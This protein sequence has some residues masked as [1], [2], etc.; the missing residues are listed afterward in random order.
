MV[1]ADIYPPRAGSG[2]KIW[3]RDAVLQGY[4]L[5]DPRSYSAR[6]TYIS[7]Q[8]TSADKLYSRLIS[9]FHFGNV[10]LRLS[11]PPRN[12]SAPSPTLRDI[13]IEIR[14]GHSGHSHSVASHVLCKVTHLGLSRSFTAAT[15]HLC[16][17]L[18]LLGLG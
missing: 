2:Y 15:H 17:L 5:R 8:H 1:A 4:I 6:A 14:S 18:L 10:R 9:N 12:T 7:E 13:S 3:C 16:D 11:A